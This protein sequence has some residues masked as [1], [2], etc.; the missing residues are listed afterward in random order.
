[1]SIDQISGIN[2]STSVGKSATSSPQQDFL[3][4]FNDAMSAIEE[5]DQADQISNIEMLSGDGGTLH[6][7]LLEA[8]K[9]DIALRLTLEV[10]NKVIES[11]KE[12]MNMQV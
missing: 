9:A 6:G 8:E 11:Y 4:V 10:R 3:Q 7:T 12:I 1:M 2:F 5:T